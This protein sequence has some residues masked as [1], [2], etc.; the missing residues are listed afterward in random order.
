MS[1]PPSSGIVLF[2]GQEVVPPDADMQRACDWAQKNFVFPDVESK[3][4]PWTWKPHIR[5]CI[6]FTR[7]PSFFLK[8]RMRPG[9][10]RPSE[11]SDRTFLDKSAELGFEGKMVQVEDQASYH[12]RGHYYQINS[13]GVSAILSALDRE[14]QDN[15]AM[16]QLMLGMKDRANTPLRSLHKDTLFELSAHLVQTGSVHDASLGLPVA[17]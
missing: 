17:T 14:T 11:L 4:D 10:V 3:M 15:E 12:V 1:F 13:R 16:V 2:P 8:K 5:K 7:G 9:Q 6:I